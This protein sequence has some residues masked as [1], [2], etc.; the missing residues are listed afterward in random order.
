MQAAHLFN[1]IPAYN[2]Q[3]SH[4]MDGSGKQHKTTTL[5]KNLIKAN[6]LDSFL[7]KNKEDFN[8]PPFHKYIQSICDE[9]HISAE[10]IIKSADIDRT[11]GHQLFNGTRNP[12]RDNVIKLAIA[13]KFNLEQTQKLLCIAGKSSLYPRIERDSVIVFSISKG[14]DVQ[15]VQE[16]L[17]EHNLSLLGKSKAYEELS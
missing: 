11:Y 12:S 8:V 15:H 7:N 1:T 13:F 3:G 17:Y 4:A 6:N 5:M 2:Y 10:Q 9:R 16:L 14:Y